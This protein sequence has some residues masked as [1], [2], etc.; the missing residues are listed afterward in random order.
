[1]LNYVFESYQTYRNVSLLQMWW[2]TTD[3]PKLICKIKKTTN[4]EK[5]AVKPQKNKKMNLFIIS[6]SNDRDFQNSSIEKT[7]VE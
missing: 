6:C 5:N 1:M 3:E 4:P 7:I 2:F